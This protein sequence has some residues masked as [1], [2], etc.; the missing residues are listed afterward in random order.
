MQ[1]LLDLQAPTNT[2]VSLREL[3]DTTENHMRGLESLGKQKESFGD[4]LIPVVFGK[5]PSVIRRNL[6]R[7]HSSEQ[8]N[9]DELCSAIEKEIT[10]LES[11]LEKHGDQSRSTITGSFHTGIEQRRSGT[12]F[13][14]RL[15]STKPKCVYCKGPHVPTQ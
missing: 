8:W 1:A 12:Q 4:F 6:T 9:I 5:L 13:Q 15:V 3:L 10:V 7:D 2:A 14:E 11:G